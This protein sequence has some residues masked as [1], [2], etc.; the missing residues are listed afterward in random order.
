MSLGAGG[1]VFARVDTR[2]DFKQRVV[3]DLLQLQIFQFAVIA[4]FTQR[5]NK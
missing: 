5:M 4:D 2:L 3:N 1:T